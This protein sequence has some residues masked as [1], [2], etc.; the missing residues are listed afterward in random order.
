MRLYRLGLPG[1]RL[2]NSFCPLAL[3]PLLS[4]PG[5][6]TPLQAPRYLPFTLPIPC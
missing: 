2:S 6:R 4:A 3:T 5:A 1:R